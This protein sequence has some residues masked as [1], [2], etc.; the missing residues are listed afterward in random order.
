MEM[1]QPRRTGPKRRRCW[2]PGAPSGV[3]CWQSPLPRLSGGSLGCPGRPEVDSLRTLG[4]KA[5][6]K[7]LS[8]GE[9]RKPEQR[10]GGKSEAWTGAGALWA[11][12]GGP[13]PARSGRLLPAPS[14]CLQESWTGREAASWSWANISNS[15]PKTAQADGLF[16][17]EIQK[18]SKLNESLF[19]S[20][21]L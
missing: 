1:G 16:F 14:K 20:F 6:S 21:M 5:R 10:T 3:C 4:L 2:A 15:R 12:G 11:G 18:Q 17:G 9:W 7:G 19:F 8:S 13:R